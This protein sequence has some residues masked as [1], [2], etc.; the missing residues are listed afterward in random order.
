MNPLNFWKHVRQDE[1][2]CWL[3]TGV[4]S[5]RGYGQWARLR[6][7]LSAHRVAWEHLRGEIPDGLQV[8][9]LCAVKHCVNPWHMELVN[10]AVNNER[11][12]TA[13]RMCPLPPSTAA[14][15]R[16]E[17][18][19]EREA[20]ERHEAV[21]RRLAAIDPADTRT[22]FDALFGGGM[23]PRSARYHSVA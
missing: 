10:A 1:N 5:R 11:R 13:D 15:K 22:F 9:H 4:V 12:V 23:T 19:V 8:D 14:W 6:K 16:P 7:T 17:T 2:G 21:D 18:Q 20:R 3:W